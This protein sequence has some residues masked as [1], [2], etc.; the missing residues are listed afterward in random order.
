M[1]AQ[2]SKVPRRKVKGDDFIVRIDGVDYHPHAGEEVE[3][4]T[5]LRPYDLLAIIR[6]QSFRAAPAI[7]D[8]TKQIEELRAFLTERIT[9][10][11]WTNDDGQAYAS[12]D[13]MMAD[14]SWEELG[15][16]IDN[17]IPERSAAEQ[18]EEFSPS[19]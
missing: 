18:G 6:F 19:T 5:R 11:S 7:E 3:L 17:C 10:T 9:A 14:V 8:M 16:L 13:D 15:W 1:A 12:V 2:L 4:K